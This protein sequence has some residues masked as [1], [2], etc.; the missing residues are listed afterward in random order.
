[1]RVL[2]LGAQ[3]QLGAELVHT[4]PGHTLL[5]HTRL[6]AD[7]TDAAALERFVRG[8]APEIVLNTAAFNRTE[9]CEKDPVPAF[10]VNT[11]APR[12]LAS[13]CAGLGARLVHFSTDFV[14]DGKKGA[15]YVETDPPNPMTVYALSKYG[16]ER[17][18]LAASETNMVCRTAGLYGVTGSR[19]KGGNFVQTVLSRAR[20]G[21][22]LRVVDDIVMSPTYARDLA[23]KVWELL[24]R[25]VPGGTYHLTNGGGCTWFQFAQAVLETAGLSAP[26]APISSAQ[27][28]GSMRRSPDTR[29]VSERLLALG[30]RPLRPWRE[31]LAA[32]FAQNPLRPA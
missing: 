20:N 23:E 31:A 1:M 13:L 4:N 9:L 17:F 14:F 2:L 10:A 19:S 27:W 26:L 5:L 15:P 8:A 12:A 18:V 7:L 22:T 16:G 25:K 30:I 29:L 3:G 11:L 28:S 24:D 32:Y 6:D 21:E